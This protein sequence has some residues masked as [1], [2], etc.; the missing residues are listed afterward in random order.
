[1]GGGLGGGFHSNKALGRKQK[2]KMP[3]NNQVQNRQF[4]DVVRTLKL[5]DNQARRLHDFVSDGGFSYQELLQIARE[6]FDK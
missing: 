2:G 4:K 6:M 3:M 1:M 5:N